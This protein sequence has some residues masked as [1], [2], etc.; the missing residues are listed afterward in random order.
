MHF[1]IT[2]KTVAILGCG[3]IGLMGVN[4]AK[5]IDAKKIIA[6][7]VNEYRRQFA[8]RVGAHVVIDPSKEDVVARVMEETEG[9]GVDV[10]G[11]FSG[12][13]TAIEAAFKY[14]KRGGKMSLLGLGDNKL[15]IDFSNDIVFKGISIYGV[16]GRL[17]FKTWEQIQE[18]LASGKLDLEKIVTHVFP[19]EKM[20]EAMATMIS[21]N[22]GKVVLI[23]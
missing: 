18:L 3:P 14:V 10:V 12:N 15:E 20:E 13:K 21:G 5:A 6:I 2:G 11:E 19:L 4:I 8:K 1:P 17:M 22:C 16:V 9:E 23:P 7:E